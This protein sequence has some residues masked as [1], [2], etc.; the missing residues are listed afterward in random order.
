VSARY[1][2]LL[3]GIVS[4]SGALQG[5]LQ[6]RVILCLPKT[7]IILACTLSLQLELTP[8]LFFVC[9]LLKTVDTL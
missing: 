3:S 9:K 1:V 2:F 6:V 8:Q 7:E 5:I 4:L